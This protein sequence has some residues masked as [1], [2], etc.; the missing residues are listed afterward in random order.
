MGI[1]NERLRKKAR[2]VK[3][4]IFQERKLKFRPIKSRYV[5]SALAAPRD[6]T[7]SSCH[8]LIFGQVLN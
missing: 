7:H 5:I 6:L 8:N 2:P 4:I 1:K 3:I